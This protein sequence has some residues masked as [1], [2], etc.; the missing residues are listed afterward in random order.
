VRIE[1]G[2]AETAPATSTLSALKRR[3]QPKESKSSPREDEKLPD[4]L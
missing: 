3:R 2:K 1:F 4:C